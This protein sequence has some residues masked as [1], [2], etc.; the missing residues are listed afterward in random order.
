M[1]EATNPHRLSLADY[2]RPKKV[3][4]AAT[5]PDTAPAI[6]YPIVGNGAPAKQEPA[7]TFPIPA[8]VAAAKVPATGPAA[9]NPTRPNT[10]GAAIGAMMTPPTIAAAATGTTRERD[11]TVSKNQ[12]D[13][14][15]SRERPLIHGVVV[16]RLGLER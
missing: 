4:P 8:W 11:T 9:L 13:T 15:L 14:I 7:T 5:V 2:P 16:R 10:V 6:P 1:T 3:T 12:R